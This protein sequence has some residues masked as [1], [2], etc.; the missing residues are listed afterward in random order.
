V[1]RVRAGGPK[2]KLIRPRTTYDSRV[3]RLRVV[4]APV[5]LLV[6]SVA[7]ALNAFISFRERGLVE[8]YDIPAAVAFFAAAV[9]AWRR[10]LAA[11]VGGAV[12]CGI[13]LASVVQ[14][15]S[16]V[17]IAYWIVALVLTLQALPLARRGRATA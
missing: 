12:L 10:S 13:Y 7:F 4:I 6:P 3:D 8:P 14:S 17:F 2:C 9:L 11:L 16:A 15:G 1:W 5:A